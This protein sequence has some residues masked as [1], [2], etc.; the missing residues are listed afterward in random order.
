MAENEIHAV[1]GVWYKEGKTFYVC[2]SDRMTNY[3]DVWSLLSIQF[4][5]VTFQEQLNLDYVR[6]LMERMSRERLGG[7][8][9][10]VLR[11]LNSAQ[12]SDNPMEKQVI[13]HMYEIELD[14]VPDLNPDFYCDGAWLTPSEYEE[15][16]R[17][18]TCGLCLRMWSDYCVRN[19]LAEHAFA[20]A[21]APQS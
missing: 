10:T 5:P 2:R 19:S 13:L 3:P 21:L 18:A 15:R 8:G 11:Y 12:C 9:I 16:S 14:S 6:S 4:D 17:G 7:V 20:P 1:I